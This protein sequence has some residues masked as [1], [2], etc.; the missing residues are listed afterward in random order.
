MN[1]GSVITDCV[2]S[3]SCMLNKFRAILFKIILTQSCLSCLWF[4]E[5][6]ADISEMSFTALTQVY[7][8]SGGFW[9]LYLCA[10]LV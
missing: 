5:K 1:W 9:A 10:G 3:Y 8:I 2:V 4:L 7:H 6:L